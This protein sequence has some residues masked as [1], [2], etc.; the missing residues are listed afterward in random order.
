MRRVANLVVLM[1]S[2][3]LAAPAG[4]E[5]AETAHAPTESAETQEGRTTEEIAASAF[6]AST[7]ET[8]A[9]ANVACFG[10]GICQVAD[11]APICV[12][13]QGYE[14][15][16]TGMS[17]VNVSSQPEE[18]GSAP[19]A[20][21]R[22]RELQGFWPW[23]FGIILMP[24]GAAFM[25]TGIGLLGWPGGPT[26]AAVALITVGGVMLLAGIIQTIVG[27]VR[28][29]RDRRQRVSSRLNLAPAITR[30]NEGAPVG[31]CGAFF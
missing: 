28:L 20:E 7:S 30:R 23:L 15:D 27:G 21:V 8:D 4:A 31:F 1:L 6:T 2:M 13:H 19:V 12:C 5:D 29:R 17:C 26:K 24:T 14:P 16:E 10:Q 11:G 25:G 9:C 18:D 3:L 22:R